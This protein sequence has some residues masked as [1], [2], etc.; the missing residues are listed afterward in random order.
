VATQ[1]AAP[2]T[3]AAKRWHAVGIVAKST[4]CE[5]ARALRA[6]RFLSA[7]AP[8][9]PLS[10]CTKPAECSC[11]YKHFADRRAGARRQDEESGIRGTSKAGQERRTQR[12]RRDTES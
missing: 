1:N 10:Q 6:T 8:R 9:L 2:S 12:D 5:A 11:A 3:K 7:E 4:A